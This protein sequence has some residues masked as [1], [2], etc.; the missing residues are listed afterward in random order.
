MTHNEEAVRFGVGDVVLVDAGRP[1]T[2]FAG[3][4]GESWSTMALVLPRQALVSHL[5]VQERRGV[6]YIGATERCSGAFSSI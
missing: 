3:N 5:G 1:A 2:F 4:A 6:G